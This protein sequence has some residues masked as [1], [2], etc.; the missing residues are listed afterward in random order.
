MHENIEIHAGSSGF[1]AVHAYLSRRID[2]GDL[3]PILESSANAQYKS[4]E[5]EIVAHFLAGNKNSKQS[6]YS[7]SDMPPTVLFCLQEL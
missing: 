6:W 4:Q 1:W 2:N 5:E 7:Y 3:Q